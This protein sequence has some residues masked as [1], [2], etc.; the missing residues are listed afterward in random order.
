M[1]NKKNIHLYICLFCLLSLGCSSLNEHLTKLKSPYAKDRIDAIIW[2]TDNIKSQTSDELLVEALTKDESP[3][4][5]SLAIRVM[6]EKKG[7]KY[8]PLIQNSLKD[9]HYLVRMEAAQAIGTYQAT[10]LTADLAKQLQ[11]KDSHLW[12]KLKVLKSIEH[13]NA[14]GAVKE[15]IESLDDQE[16]AVRL[17][18]VSLLEKFTE[19][20]FGSNKK[21]WLEWYGK[22]NPQS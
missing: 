5:R 13:M 2:L 6:V 20:N 22:N 11:K 1:T 15:L 21:A 7:T 10:E 3:L 18:A 9:K 16:P 14:K 19:Q 4:V 17:Q 8:L 12:D